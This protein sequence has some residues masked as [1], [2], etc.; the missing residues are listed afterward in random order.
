[1]CGF[2]VAA[3]SESCS[4]LCNIVSRLSRFSVHGIKKSFGAK[5]TR[6]QPGR[7]TMKRMTHQCAVVIPSSLVSRYNIPEGNPSAD[8][9]YKGK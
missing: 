8:A 4:E 2:C 9:V 7:T 6:W 5:R 3:F 1:M